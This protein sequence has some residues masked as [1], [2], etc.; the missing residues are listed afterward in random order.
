M[1]E[2]LKSIISSNFVCIGLYCSVLRLA[3]GETSRHVYIS[4]SIFAELQSTYVKNDCCLHRTALGCV[5][6]GV[7]GVLCIIM[8]TMFSV[9]YLIAGADVYSS[10]Q[11]FQNFVDVPC[12]RCSQ[13]TGVTVRLEETQKKYNQL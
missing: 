12:P 13:E 3:C 2:C 11:I 4:V 10:F 1:Q 6:E 8:H 5:C 7:W 9:S